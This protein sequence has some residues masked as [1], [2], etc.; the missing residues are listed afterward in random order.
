[1]RTDCV[2]LSRGAHDAARRTREAHEA[3]RPTDLTRTPETFAECIGEDEAALY[4]LIW[5]R[6]VASRMA[7]ARLDRARVELVSEAGDIVLAATGSHIVFDGFLRLWRE[8]GGE[9]DGAGTA[10]GPGT[11]GPCRG[12]R[13]GRGCS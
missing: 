5:T 4:V 11:N 12:W 3:I 1:M 8:G 13:R 9:E 10:A 2:G 7:A 6:A